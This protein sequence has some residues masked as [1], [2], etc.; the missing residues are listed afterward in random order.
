MPSLQRRR[1]RPAVI[2]PYKVEVD[3]RGSPQRVVD[4]SPEAEIHVVAAFIPQRSSRAELPGQMSIEIVRM[5]VRHSIEGF[6]LW[7]RVTYD[8]K[9]WDVA[10]PPSYRHGTRHTRHVSVDLRRRP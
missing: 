5:I 4:M 9:E 8:G 7:A 2:H 3:R 10:A 6:D 1:G